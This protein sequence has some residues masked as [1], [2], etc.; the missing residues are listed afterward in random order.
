MDR[1]R[2]EALRKKNAQYSYPV[3]AETDATDFV[4]MFQLSHLNSEPIM[5]FFTYF[6]LLLCLLLMKRIEWCPII[7]KKRVAKVERERSFLGKIKLVEFRRLSDSQVGLPLRL[8]SYSVQ[9]HPAFTLPPIQP[10]VGL[11]RHSES[12]QEN[13]TAGHRFFKSALPLPN[14]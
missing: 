9:G 7:F 5:W 13:G 10:R 6:K 14:E 4:K 2:L 1:Y 8:A 3:S 11:P 12:A